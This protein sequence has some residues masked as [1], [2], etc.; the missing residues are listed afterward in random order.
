LPPDGLEVDVVEGRAGVLLPELV[1]K[2]VEVGDLTERAGRVTVPEIIAPA[3]LLPAAPREVG[4]K[5]A[6]V[7]VERAHRTRQLAVAERLGH[8]P[9]QLVALLWGQRPHQPLA[10]GGPAGD[11]GGPPVGPLARFP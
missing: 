2:L 6:E 10:G 7:G 3:Y 9:G 5:R 1:E 4:A 11:D 8:Q